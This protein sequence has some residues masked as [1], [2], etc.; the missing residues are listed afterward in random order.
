MSR[1]RLRSALAFA[2]NL[3]QKKEQMTELL[4]I[5]ATWI[6]DLTIWP[7][8]PDSVINS[9]YGEVLAHVRAGMDDQRLLGM[10]QA[11]EKAQ[12]RRL[13]TAGWADNGRN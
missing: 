2:A 9:D 1:R 5:L 4:E 7:Y 8:H 10:W 3:A 13:P 12:K 6:R 11:V